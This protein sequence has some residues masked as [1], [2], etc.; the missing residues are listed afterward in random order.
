MMMSVA[1]KLNKSVYFDILGVVIVFISAYFS[2]FLFNDLTTTIIGNQWW[3]KYVPFGLISALSSSLSLMSTRLVGKNKNS[4]NVIGIISTVVSGT[5]DYLLGNMGAIFTYP[6]SFVVNWL[7]VHQWKN[8]QG[9]INYLVN[10]W[11]LVI[12]VV[13]AFVVGFGLNYLAFRGQVNAIFYLASLTFSLSLTANILNVLKIKEEWGF[14]II[15][16]FAQLVKAI[17]QGNF[18]NVG[19]YI[20]YLFNGGF[21]FVVWQ[22]QEQ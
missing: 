1:Q 2:G 6:V 18:A 3:A 11:L 20:Y 16:N 22:D 10:K 15:Y 17:V 19:K 7:S 13:G 14:W 5:I 12:L 8:Y 4:G 9:K 21:A